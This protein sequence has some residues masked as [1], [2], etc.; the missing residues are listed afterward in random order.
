MQILW[1]NKNVKNKNQKRHLP[2]NASCS[3]DTGAEQTQELL[4][5]ESLNI[6]RAK[7]R[8]LMGPKV[9]GMTVWDRGQ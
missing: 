5:P 4:A 9:S 3:N 7:K 6:E 8:R 2:W 1:I